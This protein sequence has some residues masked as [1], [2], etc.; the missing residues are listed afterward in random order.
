MV[1]LLV[2]ATAPAA[3]RS[4]AAVPGPVA[5]HPLLELRLGVDRVTEL[6]HPF[7][8]A[9][10]APLP[11]LAVE[12]CGTGSGVLHH[13]DAPDMAHF[14]AR[15]RLLE[16]ARGR[17]TANLAPG[18]GFAEV[19]RTADEPGF[20]FGEA[21]DPDPVE[22]AGPEASLGVQGRFAVDPAGRTYVS[23]DVTAG[24]A[25]VPSAPAVLGHGGPVVPFASIT[26]G[27]GF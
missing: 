6:R 4:E 7:L 17:A 14:R 15:G 13:D 25:V 12:G 27:Y 20:R 11:F 1:G 19:Q 10:L 24:A 23:A 26:V 9:E 18:V 8:C 21:R 16:V 3:T 5:G 2:A 22:G